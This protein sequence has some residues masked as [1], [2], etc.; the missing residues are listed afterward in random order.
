MTRSL[1]LPGPVVADPVPLAAQPRRATT[2]RAVQ[3][4]FLAL[5]TLYAFLHVIYMTGY[6][7]KGLYYA[8]FG[9][10]LV[11]SA[12]RIAWL[13]VTRWH[14]LGELHF[15]RSFSVLAGASAVIMIVSW[16][17]E[18]SATETLTWTGAG[19]VFF[20]LGPA[21]I[22]LCVVNTAS[23]KQL[24][25]Y[26]I[27][28]LARY[29]VYFVLAFSTDFS[30]ASLTEVSWSSS[31]SPFESS[32]AH[33]LLI[34]EAYFVFRNRKALALVAAGMT[35][36]SLKRASFVLAPAM[37]V[38][39][40]WLRSAKPASRRYLYALAAVGVASPFMVKYVYS[41]GFVEMASERFGIDINTVTTGRWEIYQIAT[42]LL[43]QTTGFGSLNPLLTN[44]VDSHFGTY[45][46]SQLHNDTLRVYMEVGFIGIAVY[47]CALVYLGRSSRMA[48]LLIT[49][50]VFVL[51]TSRLITHTSYWVA[52]F[53]VLALIERWIHERAV[54]ARLEE[55]SDVGREVAER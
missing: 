31:S 14:S 26:A 30:L 15:L 17:R 36:L 52:L 8:A 33:D 9:L 32:F 21:L 46:N 34:V 24:D 39:S 44:L 23:T 50:T 45:W 13:V 16:I 12:A 6:A 41:Q 35:M 40:R 53:L 11:A 37:I 20:I 54:A 5:F 51:I 10:L 48:S 25:G 29:A 18:Y 4:T 1:P 43:P 3:W 28:L 19:Q 2:G 38:A 7:P 47:V 42:G 22:A 27:I 55:G 49:Y